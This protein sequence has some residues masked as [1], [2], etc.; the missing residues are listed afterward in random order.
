MRFFGKR[1]RAS[2]VDALS[3]TSERQLPEGRLRRMSHAMSRRQRT[4]QPVFVSSDDAS[5]GVTT[6]EGSRQQQQGVQTAEED[7]NAASSSVDAAAPDDGAAAVGDEDEADLGKRNA[8]EE[9]PPPF[10]MALA[11]MVTGLRVFLVDQVCL[12]MSIRPF[13]HPA[14][15]GIRTRFLVV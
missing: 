9:L 8:Q 11:V 2:T 6:L 7:D 13:V 3:S 12:L 14:G 10:T 5:E 4:V 15:G 1:R